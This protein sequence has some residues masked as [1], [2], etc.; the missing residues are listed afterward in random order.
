[1][2]D[3]FMGVDALDRVFYVIPGLWDSWTFAYKSTS[4]RF[5]NKRGLQPLLKTK[6]E[7]DQELC[8]SPS[9]KTSNNLKFPV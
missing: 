7:N 5:I 2:I 1:M 3:T 9:S 6:R 8:L 4:Y